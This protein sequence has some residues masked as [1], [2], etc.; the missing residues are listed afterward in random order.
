MR[1]EGVLED[2]SWME[3]CMFNTIDS[4][5][6]LM[7]NVAFSSKENGFLKHLLPCAL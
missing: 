6:K 7:A 3:D 2:H 5:T 1:D 4:S